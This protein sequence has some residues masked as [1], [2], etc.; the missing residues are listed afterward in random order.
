L[1][2][3]RERGKE[4]KGRRVAKEYRGALLFFLIRGDPIVDHGQVVVL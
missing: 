2:G 4:K 3:I 1:R